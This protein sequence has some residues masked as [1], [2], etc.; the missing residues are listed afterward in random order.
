NEGSTASF[1]VS[2]SKAASVDVSVTLETLY[3]TANADD[4]TSVVVKDAAGNV[5][6]PNA[7]GSYTVKA[8]ETKLIVE[9]E[10]KD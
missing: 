9:V 4:I 7:D 6:T 3:G 1:D 8:G 2:L 5:V 10:T